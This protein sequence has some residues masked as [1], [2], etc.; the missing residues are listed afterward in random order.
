MSNDKHQLIVISIQ[1][2]AVRTA[3]SPQLALRCNLWWCT[4]AAA[5]TMQCGL[6]KP[7]ISHSSD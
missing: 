5:G 3:Q 2:F 6:S 4:Y 7:N 1:M